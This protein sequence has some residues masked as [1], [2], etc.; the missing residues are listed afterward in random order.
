MFGIFA[1]PKNILPKGTPY[2]LVFT[3]DDAK[4][5]AIR[6]GPCSDEGTGIV[7][8]RQNSP[9]IA[10][11]TINE[12]TYEFGHKPDARSRTWRA[13]ASSCS[14]NEIGIQ[15]QEGPEQFT[16]GVNIKI[17]AN[18]GKQLTKDR[19]WRGDITLSDFDAWNGENSV[20]VRRPGNYGAET[21]SYLSVSTVTVAGGLAAKSAEAKTPPKIRPGFTLPKSVR[22]ALGVGK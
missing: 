18:R 17:R 6:G 19:D 8:T 12:K 9:G 16:T 11:L 4:G 21:M 5:Q 13:L 7:G 2:D 3:F 15:V 20:L 22:D 14:N 1:M 10:V